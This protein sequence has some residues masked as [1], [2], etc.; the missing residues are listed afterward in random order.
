MKMRDKEEEEEESKFQAPTQRLKSLLVH[1][2]W[3][4]VCIRAE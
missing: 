1:E 4:V 3:R 2:A